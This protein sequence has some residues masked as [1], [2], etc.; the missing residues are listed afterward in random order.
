LTLGSKSSK[1][2]HYTEFYTDGLREK[3]H[4]IYLKDIQ[5]FGYKF[6]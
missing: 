1:T 5:I 2:K 4:Q 3:V 6:Y